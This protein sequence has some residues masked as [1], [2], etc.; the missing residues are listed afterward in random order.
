MFLRTTVYS[1]FCSA[2]FNYKANWHNILPLP[3]YSEENAMILGN[4]TLVAPKHGSAQLQQA[5][6][7]YDRIK[8]STEIPLFYGRKHKD[9]I[10]ACLP[11]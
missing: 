10:T 6:I 4:A 8:R 11:H 5:L 9:S 3:T 2:V 1:L 7:N